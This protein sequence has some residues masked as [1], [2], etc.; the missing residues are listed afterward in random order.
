MAASII[1]NAIQ[2]N[3]D[4]VLSL[5]DEGMVTMFKTLESTGLRGFLVS[6]SAI[7]EG[8]L[9]TFFSNALVREKTVI[10][11]VQGKFIK[12]SEEQFAGVF[13]LSSE[14]LMTDMVTPYSNQALGF[15]VKICVLLK[16]AP[17]LTLGESKPFPPLNIL[18]VKTVGTYVAKNKTVSTTA[19][20]VTDEPVVEKVVKAALIRRP[21]PAAEPVAKKKRT[22]VGSAAPT[23][24]TFAIV[25]VVQESVPITVVPAES[26]RA[27]R[28]QAPNVRVD[29]QLANLW[30][31]GSH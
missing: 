15:V 31:V 21:A 30:H 9:D 3:F 7:Y 26:P 27:Q 24:K 2:I 29:A 4:S 12:I 8:D 14:G 16:G 25:P 11:S 18:T 20:E 19:E 13:E 28:H 1:Q 10:S 23:K 22:T 6:S 5:S 17:D